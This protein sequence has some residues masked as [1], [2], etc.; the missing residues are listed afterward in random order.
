MQLY[1]QY[2]ITTAF[3]S[4]LYLFTMVLG[5]LGNGMVIYS[6]V[7]D[8]AI[9][10]TFNFILTNLAIADFL[11]CAL[12]TPLLF[13]YRIH[14][15]AGIIGYTP[16]CE[17]G[18]LLSMF[19]VSLM[20]FVFPLLAYQ[21]REVT[22]RSHHSRLSLVQARLVM[23]V[24]WFLSILSGVMMVL[25]ARREF[26]RSDPIYP[27]IYR[28]LSINQSLDLFTQV[29]Q[30]LRSVQ[31]NVSPGAPRTCFEFVTQLLRHPRPQGYPVYRAVTFLWPCAAVYYA[32]N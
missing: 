22:L 1:E 29:M 10:R 20:F 11:I 27:N 26:A 7:T 17:L 5:S 21:R 19:S 23:R 31:S 2:P 6:Y 12:F 8:K 9:H 3:V 18:I 15:K 25:M 32:V 28:C 30:I 16:L 24:F 14:E 13:S 4:P